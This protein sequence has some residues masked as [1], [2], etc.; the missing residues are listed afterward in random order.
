MKILLAPPSSASNPN[1][2]T[3]IA[4][5]RLGWS[6]ATPTTS[7]SHASLISA[8]RAAELLQGYQL[9]LLAYVTVLEL[10][11]AKSEKAASGRNLFLDGYELIP[12]N[13]TDQDGEPATLWTAFELPS[14]PGADPVSLGEGTR[15]WECLLMCVD[16]E[17]RLSPVTIPVD[18]LKDKLQQIAERLLASLH[19]LVPEPEK[20]SRPY[21]RHKVGP[22]TAS[23][24]A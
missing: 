5:T 16:R 10:A 23:H 7:S 12:F 11:K 17:A 9:A 8:I 4:G 1:S 13:G 15:L 14:S 21:R 22:S 19:P 2:E 18:R 6:L 24:S 3:S 20:V